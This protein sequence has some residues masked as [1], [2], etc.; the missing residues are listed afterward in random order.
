MTT[1]MLETER[2]LLRPAKIADAQAIYN[3]WT[4]DPDVARFMRWNVHCSVEET[5]EWL[6]RT[7]A[8]VANENSYDW[9]FVL[10]ETNEPI[11][12]G[13]VFYSKKHDMFEI[14]YGIMKA[15]WGQG[16]ATETAT[17]IMEFAVEEL[18]KTQ[19]YACHA[20]ENPA[21]GSILKKLGF[22]YKGDG[23]YSSFDGKRVFQCKEYFYNCSN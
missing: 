16:F 10:K 20:N 17:A 22:V 19:L 7:V 18:G 8:N 5:V 23:E 13:G 11:G 6:A 21:S 2:M 15:R 4:S 9:L 3:N 1:P 14:G 12:S